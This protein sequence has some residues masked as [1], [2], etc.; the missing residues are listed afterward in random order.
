M[1]AVHPVPYPEQ[2]ARAMEYIRRYSATHGYPPS[3]GDLA[4]FLGVKHA[5]ASQILDRMEAEGLIQRARG[6][7]YTQSRTIRLTSAA[8]IEPKE[9]M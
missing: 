1:T 9:S 5:R 6:A 2:R 8:M 4:K 3:T 7:R